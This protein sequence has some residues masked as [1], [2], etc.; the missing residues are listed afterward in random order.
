M[1]EDD[2]PDPEDTIEGQRALDSVDPDRLLSGEDPNTIYVED[3]AHWVTVYSEL[4]LFKERLLDTAQTGLADLSESV[5]RAEAAA[6][7]LVVLSAER[8]R[9]R[10]RLDFWKGRQRELSD[11][12]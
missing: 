7:D 2:S 1:P 9:L 8:D 4:V 10:S 12:G 6:T 3:A 11:R 5:A